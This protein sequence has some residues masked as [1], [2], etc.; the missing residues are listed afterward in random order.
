MEAMAQYATNRHTLDM[1][2]I[3]RLVCESY[4]IQESQLKVKI[5]QEGICVQGRNTIFI[6][7]AK[8]TSLS[9]EDIGNVFN[10]R[11]TTVMRNITAV[12]QEL[13]RQS[14]VGRQI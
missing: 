10:R 4:G 2:E 6:W 13:A 9:L 5:A 12:E 8:H 11:H 7:R 1:P 14:V 3:I